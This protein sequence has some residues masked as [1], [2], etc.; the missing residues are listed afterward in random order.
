[1][2]GQLHAPVALTPET[3]NTETVPEIPSSS[4]QKVKPNIYE[5]I[6]LR[7]IMVSTANIYNK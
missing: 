4:L 6:F 1:M 2:S 3:A 7:T 5:N